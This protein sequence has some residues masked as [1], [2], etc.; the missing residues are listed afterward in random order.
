MF[1]YLATA[2]A[3]KFFSL[4]PQTK[5]LYRQLG[6]AWGQKLKVS[7]GLEPWRLLN[8]KEILAL[9][10]KYPVRDGDRVLE[11]GTGW[12]HWESTLIRL[13]Y[14]VEITLF[15][16]W[17]NRQFD[18][19]KR[20]FALYGAIID[21]ELQLTQAQSTRVHRVLQVIAKADSFDEVYGA[22]GFHYVVHP[23]GSTAQFPNDYFSL[24]V[25]CNVLEHVQHSSLSDLISD[26]CRIL[27]PGGYMFH[28]IDLGDHLAYYYPS[29]FRKNYLR[30]SD[31]A[32]RRFFGNEV[33]Y[34]NRV[35]PPEWFKLFRS[36]GLQLIDVR[37][38]S[39]N[40]KV[41]VDPCFQD[42]SQD[43]LRT[44]FLMLV[45]QKV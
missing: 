19:Y 18:A 35:Q 6:N 28:G 40:L 12:V 4:S 25:S 24:I 38:E 37:T 39:I 26:Y 43:E 30:Y 45:H 29:V 13:F 23:Q 15:D 21:S 8:A 1:K 16:A 14:D 22:L 31:A 33:Q 32:W 34:F 44:L 20:Y 10:A 42:L 5:K 36:A 7:H 17:D 9:C 27:K 41:K 2:A 3:L 11:I